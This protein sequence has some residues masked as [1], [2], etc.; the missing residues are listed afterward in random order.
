MFLFKGEFGIWFYKLFDGSAPAE[1]TGCKLELLNSPNFRARAAERNACPCNS[2][3]AI[4]DN[5]WNRVGTLPYETDTTLYYRSRRVYVIA[6]ESFGGKETRARK[7]LLTKSCGVE[8]F[9]SVKSG[10]IIT[11]Y[12]SDCQRIEIYI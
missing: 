7:V 4:E 9:L 10:K 6:S 8:F 5:R 3:Q 2:D 11:I 1:P 12:R